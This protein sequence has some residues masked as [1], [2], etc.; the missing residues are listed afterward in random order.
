[1][2][3]ST[4]GKHCLTRLEFGY[5]EPGVQVRMTAYESDAEIS[6]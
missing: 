5:A 4:D 1:M 3:N 2:K 6:Y